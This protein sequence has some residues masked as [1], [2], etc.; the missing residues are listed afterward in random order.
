MKRLTTDK[1]ASEMSMI[2]L[3]HNSCYAD[4]ERRA[5]YRD[6]ELDIDARD[7]AKMLINDMCNEDLSSMTDEE[8]DNYIKEMLAD[9]M[10]SQIGLI[11]LFY[12]NVWAMA[13]LREKL[14][15][16]E[17]TGMTPEQVIEMQMDWVAIKAA[18][19]KWIPVTERLPEEHDSIFA[20]F[21][22][23][24]KWKK[25]MFAKVSDNVLATIKCEDGEQEICTTAKTRDGEWKNDF[26]RAYSD[27]KIT[28]WM[29]FPEPYKE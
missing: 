27:A 19:P 22:G 23:T 13:D 8:F 9:G 14:A 10:N 18:Y 24:E 17:D 21:K 25:G 2:E 5:R 26:L 29:P 20:K 12:R 6:Y 11:A 3:A 1:N 16:Y 4:K 28:A 15:D 7:L